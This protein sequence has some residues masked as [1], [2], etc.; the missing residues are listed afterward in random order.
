MFDK[1]ATLHP[2]NEAKLQIFV[3]QTSFKSTVFLPFV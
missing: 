3:L 1:F 2:E